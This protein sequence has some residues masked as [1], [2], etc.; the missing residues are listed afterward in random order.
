MNVINIRKD[1][2]RLPRKHLGIALSLLLILAI[3]AGVGL[4]SA[5]TVQARDV[6]VY[7]DGVQTLFPDQL[8]YIDENGRTLVPARFCSLALGAA[9]D[10]D[11]EHQ[12]AVISRPATDTA[13]ARQVTL[14]IGNKEMLISGESPLQMDTAAVLINGRTMVPLRFISE[15]FAAQVVWD[16]PSRAVHVFTQ[17]QTPAEQA[18]IIQ[19]AT[20]AGADLPRLNSAE[21]LQRLLNEY[22][23]GSPTY[24]IRQNQMKSMAVDDAAPMPAPQAE[25]LKG[26]G[27]ES[28]FSGTNVQVQGVDESDIVKTDGEY[29]Y[30]VK[31]GQ[32]IIVKACPPAE[33]QVVAK[34]PVTQRPREMYIDHNRLVLIQDAGGYYYPAPVP[35]EITP[36][37]IAPDIYP[38]PSNRTLIT[39]FD[40]SDKSHPV[41]GD[42]YATPGNYLSSRKIGG[43]IYIISTES[44]YRPFEP[45]Y[46]INNKEYTKTYDQ[47]RYFPDMQLN[48]YMNIAQVQLSPAGNQFSLETFLGSGNNVFCSQSNLYIAASHY[49]PTYYREGRLADSESTV[50]YKF[51]LGDSVRYSSRGLV[52]GRILNQFSMDEYDGYFRIATTR[53]GWSADRAGNAVYI[54]NAGMKQ[55]S[56][57]ED[58]APGE[59]IYSARFM[60]PRAYLVTFKQVDPL[61]VIDMNPADPKILGKLKIPGFSNY[62]HPYGDHYL[63]GLGSEV[64][65][66]GKGTRITGLKL[67]LFDVTDVNNPVEVS[68]V[69][70][71]ARGTRSEAANNHKAFMMHQDMLAFPV[72]VYEGN[73]GYGSFAFQGAYVYDVSPQGFT[74]QGRI[75]HLDQQD[76]LK[77]GDYWG[78]SNRE[79]QRIVYINGSLYTL[80]ESMIKANQSGTLTELKRI[81]T[82]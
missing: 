52:P 9:V 70:I 8:P 23:Q 25:L 41:K 43:N 27:Q 45:V 20:L 42:E 38:P 54:L 15:F 33:M 64:E 4:L 7:I 72:T 79:I 44:V 34:L 82:D 60:G 59:K 68:K 31:D 3:F 69:V 39:V 21:N 2:M 53:E 71:G 63:I 81:T 58:I 6:N 14:T 30:Q 56:A 12:Q 40:T 65:E 48:S 28:S 10:W 77:A 76:Y 19:K 13:P 1:V 62:L 57:I 73:D 66:V 37:R 16:A 35:M 46:S 11:N 61:F 50:I 29:L 55:V 26:A 5:A 74:L 24:G 78:G 75:T 17:G 80:S 49:H 67:S 18:A 36:K 51:G 22:N 32:V 47:I